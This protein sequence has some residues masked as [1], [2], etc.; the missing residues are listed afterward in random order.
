MKV[1]S[2]ILIPATNFLRDVEMRGMI[3]DVNAAADLYEN[4]VLPEMNRLIMQMREATDKPLFNPR[5]V[6]HLEQL[7]YKEWRVRH[8]MQKRPKKENSV[9]SVARAE[10]L[11][12]A[13]STVADEDLVLLITKKL[14][15]YKRLQK[16]AST[17]IVSLVNRAIEDPEHRVYTN[18]NLFTT[19]SG[20]LSSTEPNLQNI[21][22]S[23][24]DLPDIRKLFIAPDG[25]KIVQADYSQAEL[26]VIAHVSQDEALVRI[27][28]D[29]L[30]LHSEVAV[31]FYGKDYTKE[32]RSK[33]KNMNFGVVYGQSSHTFK[34]KHGIPEAEGEKFIKWWWKRFNG[35]TD[36]VGKT[37]KLAHDPGYVT[38]PFGR[39][40]RF[41]L[42]TRENLPSTY[43]EAVNFVPQSTAS[44]LTLLSGVKLAHEVDSARAGICL[45]VHDSIIAEVDDDY[46]DEYSA[47]CKQ[48][49]E[50]TALKTLSWDLP[51]TSDVGH[52]ASWGLIA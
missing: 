33:C 16:Q 6:V 11:S 15:R 10:I 19:V 14:E 49:M 50:E 43:R 3:Y 22:R 1:Y 42:L 35:V 12:G 31:M 8:T 36:W 34:E 30:D 41:H 20:R 44:D 28:R 13:F 18:L 2:D 38:S 46:V 23:K 5:S 4:D 39:R 27:Y 52:G 25:R 29:A 48:I 51:F 32:Q 7:Y 24:D 47:I 21:T 26:R 40:R 17:Y 45:L 37:Q 9:D